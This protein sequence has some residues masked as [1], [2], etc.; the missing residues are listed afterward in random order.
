MYTFLLARSIVSLYPY[1]DPINLKTYFHFTDE[2][3]RTQKKTAPDETSSKRQ[4]WDLKPN[5]M[6]LPIQ[7][8]F[9]L[10][11]KS[12]TMLSSIGDCRVRAQSLVSTIMKHQLHA[13]HRPPRGP[14]IHILSLHSHNSKSLDYLL[15]MVRR[16]GE[17]RELARLTGIRTTQAI[18]TATVT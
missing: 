6:F 18:F 1:R 12:K 14:G 13:Q 7:I 16:G 9:H 5:P 8:K 10:T 17:L 3:A 11:H 4:S 15:L 2:E